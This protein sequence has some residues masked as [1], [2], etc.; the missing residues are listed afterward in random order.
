VCSVV[1]CS[2]VVCSVM[3][4]S[5]VVCSVVVMMAYPSGNLRHLVWRL[6]KLTKT[7]FHEIKSFLNRLSS[8]SYFIHFITCH[9]TCTRDI[10]FK[11]IVP[12]HIPVASLIITLLL[13]HFLRRAIQPCSK[14][15]GMIHKF[16]SEQLYYLHSQTN[17]FH[18]F[19]TNRWRPQLPAKIFRSE[20]DE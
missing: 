17:T 8:C 3:V 16:I 19:S 9:C 2:V 15:K 5:M 4:Y 20:C 12:E 6:N 10:T 18:Y 14:R 1:V 11:Q 7:Q 13:C